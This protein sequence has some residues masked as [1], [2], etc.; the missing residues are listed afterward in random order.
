[1]AEKELENDLRFQVNFNTRDLWHDENK[2]HF[3]SSFTTK[4]E[5]IFLA[6]NIKINALELQ[7]K[8]T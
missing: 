2:N 7:V 6:K 8:K 5:R 4:F 1:M 3:L